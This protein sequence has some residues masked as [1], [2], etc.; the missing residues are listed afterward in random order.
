MG[1][2]KYILWAW[3][4]DYINLGAGAELG[5]YSNMSSIAGKKV[6]CPFASQWLVDTK[7]AMKMS[8]KLIDSEGNTIIDYSPSE[9]QWWI[10][11]FNSNVK[12]VFAGSFDQDYADTLTA[13]YTVTFNNEYMYQAFY[14]KFGDKDSN[15]YNS[16][17]TFN[18]KTITGT[19]KF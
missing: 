17:W 6:T 4:G 14:D 9:K 19:L 16:N 10:T 15:Y 13:I 8:M 5:I 7:L 11:G 2:R 1:N 12:N 18:P 3:K